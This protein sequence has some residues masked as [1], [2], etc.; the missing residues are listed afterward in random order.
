ML[1]YH[2][3]MPAL[4]FQFR[5]I[6]T[7]ATLL[8]MALFIYLGQWQS[9][10]G[11]RLAAQLEQRAQR[12]QLGVLPV[13]ATLLDAQQV[14]DMALTVTG[15]YDAALQILLD[16]RQENGQPGVHVITPL[17]IDGS[18]TRILVNR[19]WIGWS[20]GRGVRPQVATPAGRVQITGL[21]QVPSAKKFF[22]MP[23]QP[24][25]PDWLWSRIDLARF[26]TRIG[27]PLQPVVLQQTGGDAPDA[28]L[29]HWPP[30]DD[31]VG[32]HQGYAWQWFGMAAALLLFYLV[33]SWRNGESA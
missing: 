22:L 19:G 14:Q 5:L 6:P 18:Q 8:G 27:H 13:T 4:R 26:E 2:R 1:F 15:S 10:K 32:K 12:G 28:L 17:K 30:P 3:F 24:Q 11:Q 33:S 20:Q 21:A 9:G 7:L 29:R 16:N 31:R 25:Q 23:D